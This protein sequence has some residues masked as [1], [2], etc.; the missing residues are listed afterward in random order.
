[1]QVQ[2]LEGAAV[3]L[4]KTVPTVG[5]AVGTRLPNPRP[6]KFVRLQRTNGF[7]RNMIQERATLLF[8]CWGATDTEAWL[9][10]VAV[11]EAFNG[12]DP[13][14]QNGIEFE[15]RV[16]SSPVNYPD[17]STASPRYTFTLETT[18]TMKGSTS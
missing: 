13:L 6:P 8:E 18:V 5:T 14:E 1:M 7:Q 16:V 4:A 2:N 10:A 15:E 12:R 9:L 11:H 17:P 3:A